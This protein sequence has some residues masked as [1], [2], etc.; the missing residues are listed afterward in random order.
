[1]SSFIAHEATKGLTDRKEVCPR[2]VCWGSTDAIS[3]PN[4][5]QPSTPCLVKC[6]SS[7]FPDITSTFR[8]VNVE[9]NAATANQV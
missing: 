7:Q 5:E 1:M 2:P 6:F 9:I 3:S 8:A 4:H